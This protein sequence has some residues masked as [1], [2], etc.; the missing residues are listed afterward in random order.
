MMVIPAIDLRGGKVVRLVEGD[1]A[2][3]TIYSDDPVTTAA[4]FEQEGA[5]LIHVVD[6]DAALSTGSDADTI[7]RI[8]SEVSVPVQVGGGL[9][10]D[11]AIEATLHAGAARAVVGTGAT[12]PPAI[13]RT[14]DRFGDRVVVAVDV[15]HGH[16]MTH[17]WKE[18]GPAVEALI[19]H[20][21]RSGCRRYLVTA[22]AADG[23]L[24]GPDLD[25][26]RRVLA[27]TDRPV[28]ASGGVTSTAD[29]RALSDLGVEAAVVGTAL[30]EG[31][32]RLHDALEAVAG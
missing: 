30:Y 21:D 7:K 5:Q 27:L 32:L 24:R 22:I 6:I 3:Q 25:L 15:R 31:R 2:R 17:G 4:R 14:I 29:L 18:Q 10:T 23:R 11:H 13:E 19:R 16:A 20:L 8:A 26:Y 1:P 12:D 28:I 9:R